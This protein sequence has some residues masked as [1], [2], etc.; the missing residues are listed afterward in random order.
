[1]ENVLP[2]QAADALLWHIQRYY[3]CGRDQGKMDASDGLHLAYLI[4]NGK[5][6]GT[7][8]AW[9]RDDW[10]KMAE[11]WASAGLIPR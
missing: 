4:Q 2:L 10:E 3:A 9:G 5:L 6:D 11:G 7:I 1:M 8:H